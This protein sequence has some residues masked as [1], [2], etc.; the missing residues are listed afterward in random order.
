MGSFDRRLDTAK[1][2]MYN[3]EGAVN[4]S[5]TRQRWAR[6]GEVCR[7]GSAHIQSEAQQGRRD[8]EAGLL[9]EERTAEPLPESDT[10]PVCRTAVKITAN[11]GASNQKGLSSQV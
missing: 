7:E 10:V 1:E 3:L 4:E 5:R 11:S 2:R 8:N 9:A 6:S